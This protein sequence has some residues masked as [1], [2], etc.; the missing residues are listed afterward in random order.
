MRSAG[1]TAAV[2]I[3]VVAAAAG[4]SGCGTAG[5]RAQASGVVQRFLSALHQRDG[6]GACGELSDDTSKQLVQQEQS[7]CA[8]A[9][10]Q[11]K[12]KPGRISRVQVFV[13]NAKVDLSSG[14]SEFLDRAPDGWE[15]SAVGCQTQG[16]PAD[17][18]YDCQ[19]EA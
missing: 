6:K 14:E 11:L 19:I 12:L 10:T 4:L 8:Q 5:D 16:K 13:T 3:A 2:A 15:L 7:A 17:R 18:P 9:V 1:R